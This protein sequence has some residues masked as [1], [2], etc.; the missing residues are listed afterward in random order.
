MRREVCSSGAVMRAIVVVAGLILAT[1][2]A[3]CGVNYEWGS[4]GGKVSIDVRPD[5]I[6]PSIGLIERHGWIPPFE[7]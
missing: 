7:R 1:T 5:L 4:Q 6:E 3:A 2:L